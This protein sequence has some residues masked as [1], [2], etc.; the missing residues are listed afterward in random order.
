[1]LT[2]QNYFKLCTK[3]VGK[4]GWEVGFCNEQKDYYEI[5]LEHQHLSSVYVRL[6]RNKTQMGGREVYR[7]TD[8]NGTATQQGVTLNYI[9][10]INNLL[11]SLEHFIC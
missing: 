3:P 7:Y 1:M 9:K 2:L 6:Q 10:D 5:K 8:S 4:M 11:K